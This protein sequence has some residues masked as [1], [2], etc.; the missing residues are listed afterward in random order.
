MICQPRQLGLITE[1]EYLS[2]LS[3]LLDYK[4]CEEFKWR[5]GFSGEHNI[6]YVISK[7]KVGSLTDL[8]S[9][10]ENIL[11]KKFTPKFVDL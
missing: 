7:V 3:Y 5:C 4:D 1:R 2:Y 10:L 11:V 6:Q 8:I 9:L